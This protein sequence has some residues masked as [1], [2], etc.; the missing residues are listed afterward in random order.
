MRAKREYGDYQTPEFFSKAVCT[1]LKETRKLTPTLIIEPTCGK[2]SFLKSSLIFNAQKIL[3]GAGSYAIVHKFTDPFYNITFA[4]AFGREWRGDA[5]GRFFLKKRS[6]GIWKFGTK[7]LIFASTFAIR[8]TDATRVLWG[9]YITQR[10]VVQVLWKNEIPFDTVKRHR[11]RW[12]R[13]GIR[14]EGYVKIQ[15]R[16][17]RVWSWLRMN[18]SDRLNTCKSRGSA[19]SDTWRR[20][21]HGW[22]TR[23]QPAAQ[24]GIT[25][26]KPD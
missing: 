18:A 2:G 17:R 6:R 24:G 10:E 26:R 11:N 3:L 15:F 22:V 9:N 12:E 13:Q 25:R 23:M 20:P 1:Y 7:V 16:Q 19:G 14:A 5:P 21:A 8:W 4:S